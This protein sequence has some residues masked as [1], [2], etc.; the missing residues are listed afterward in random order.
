MRNRLRILH[1]ILIAFLLFNGS[2][3]LAA[4]AN[5][6]EEEQSYKDLA[7]ALLERMTPEER[8]GQL[9]LVTFTGAE[10]GPRSVMSEL[11][12]QYHVGGVIL[13]AENDNFLAHDQTVIWAQDITRHIQNQA[14][15]ASQRELEDSTTG[16]IYR[17]AFVPLFIGL[18]QEGNGY[19]Y[20]QI[21]STD[22]TQLPSQMAI[23]ATWQPELARQVGSVLGSELSAL[24]INFLLGPSLDVLEPP[25]SEGSG[26]LGIRT[27]GG[28]PYWVGEMGRAFIGGVHDGSNGKIA[29]IAKHFPGYGSSDRLPEE[30]VAT[31]LKSLEQLKLFELLPFFSVTGNSPSPETTTDGLMVSH[32][33]YQGFQGENPRRTTKPVSLDPS[34]LSELLHLPSLQTW[35]QN[36]GLL[37]SDDLGSVAVKLFYR[38][39]GQEYT[40]RYVALDAFRA[41]N[42]LLYLGDLNTE[43]SEEYHIP[44]VRTIEFFNQRYREDPLFAQR[45]DESVERILELKYRLYYGSFTLSEVLA[46]ASVP[47]FVG[48]SRNVTL[49]VL[50]HSATLIWPSQSELA[51]TM[52][53]PPGRNDRI[54]FISDVRYARQCTRCPLRAQVE[55]NALEQAVVRLYS[56]GS[57]GQVLPRNLVSYTM[58]DLQ[59]MLEVGTGIVQIENDLKSAN[60]IVVLLENETSAYPSSRALKRLLDQRIDLLQQKQIVVFSLNTPHNLDST[61]ISKLSAYYALYSKVPSAIEIAA[62]LLFQDIR[63]IGSLPV[64]VP[65]A[66]YDL[67]IAVQP[68]PTQTISIFL[69]TQDDSDSVLTVTPA[70]G[71]ITGYKNGDLVPIATGVILDQN[72]HRVPDNTYVRFVITRGEGNSTQSSIMEVPTVQGI[73][74]ATVR[75]EG[76][77]QIQVRAESERARNSNTLV[78]EIPAEN[79]TP[80]ETPSP[81][82]TVTPSPTLTPTE[83]VT[84]TVEVAPLVVTP[85]RG[86]LF[87]DWLLSLLVVLGIGIATYWIALSTGQIRWG[88]RSGFLAFIGGLLVYS[89]IALKLPGSVDLVE[90]NGAWGIALL[91]LFGA[92][93]GSAVGWGWRGLR[94]LKKD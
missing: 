8:V 86:I 66:G 22:F 11:I 89:Y 65:S 58:D 90:T 49:D 80:T 45:V 48:N 46:P 15:A 36:G 50:R 63:P 13:R 75:I 44:I 4:P 93:T 72:G 32:I 17:P 73:A 79:D 64:T 25:R 51:N 28:D 74:H 1:F 9:F 21:L 16:E 37:V 61:D 2:V 18:A 38:F 41:G 84:P 30:E 83:T 67:N 69:D 76:T 94:Y 68:N 10:A 26:T 85:P 19:P 70:P 27:F 43:E 62:R 54:V 29:V 20:D 39:L 71:V 77:G 5:Q 34:A 31:V 87:G 40:G 91:T 12:G 23:G 82:S 88:V 78:F 92:V 60:W 33:R 55:I 52:P 57:G 6:E 24:G 42:D 7:R 3:G 81:T 59:E 47:N 35:R 56:P 53:E 14:Y